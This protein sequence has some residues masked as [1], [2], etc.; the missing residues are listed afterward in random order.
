MKLLIV[1]SPSK[2]KTINQYLGK[3]FNVISSYGHVRGLP[4]ADGSVKPDENFKMVYEVH[5]RSEKAVSEIIKQVKKC[6]ELLLASDPDREGEGISWHILEILKEKKILD[7][8]KVKRVVFNEITKKAVTDAVEH[9]RDINYDL[10]HAQQARQAL[11]YLYGF[12][13]SPVL[14]RKLPGSRSAGRVQSV[15]LRMI[16]DREIEIERFISTEFWSITSTMLTPKKVEFSAS[17][18]MFEGGKL[19]RFSIANQQQALAIK[20][21]LLKHSYH[22][23]NKESKQVK[24][25]PQP[26]FT[27]ST[28]L[29]EAARKLGFS[30]KKTSKIAQDLYEG[31]EIN[32]K[33]QGLITYMRTDS[34]AISS[35]AQIAARNFITSEF[36]NK[37]LP[38]KPRFYKNKS[39][40]AQEAHE[41]IRPTN[42]EITPAITLKSLSND[43][44]RL[45]ELIW[46]RLV[47]SQ[48]ES[49]VFDQ[50]TIDINS[51]DNA[52]TFRAVGTTIAFD[53]YFKLY[54]EDV[55]DSEDEDKQLLPA[56][57]VGDNVDL[58][59]LIEKQHFTQ[60][61]PRYTE[62]S[63][64]KKMEEL[65]IGRPSTY[66]GIISL[67][68]ERGYVRADKKR[69]FPEIKG[70]LV[71]SFLCAFF[72]QYVDYNFTAKLED[73]LDDIS[74]GDKPMTDVLR[75]FW[76]PFKSK[77]EEALQLKI[78]DVIDMVQND[79]GNVIY[80][81]L[82][83]DHTCPKCKIGK[84][85]IRFGKFGPFLGCSNYPNCDYTKPIADEASSSESTEA[86]ENIQKQDEVMFPKILGED[87]DGSVISLRKGP[88]GVYVQKEKGKDIKR[89]GIPKGYDLNKV[90]LSYALAM[91]S[92]PRVVGEHPDG[93]TI[94]AGIG[95][96]G[97]YLEHNKK[98]KSLKNQDP[99][100]VDL[101][102]AV[103][104][105]AEPVVARA[106]ASKP[107]AK[108]KK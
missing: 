5:E 91:L 33:T 108:K 31:M 18:I 58:K 60:P 85:S 13:L 55:D 62:A 54:M 57:E 98:F 80:K 74:I 101:A 104:I 12:T 27:T 88:Y 20:E 90:T 10:V 15:A 21:S 65:G 45:Y 68:Q 32:G 94:K 105:L 24:R 39:K 41:A 17:L 43:H 75:E 47:A 42:V 44:Q 46:K 66:P 71:S 107:A 36:G 8:I 81:D 97:P 89:T 70:R 38:E 14:W 37:Y 102:T 103:A 34:V 83:P 78:S 95:R 63:L 40:N 77:T 16:C 49:A 48:M 30:A 3:D 87:P 59:E 25:N 26:P 73:E 23:A 35:D 106:R 9:P 29:Q 19:E 56:M 6:D 11:D 72:P 99:V 1:E 53:G 76:T 7:K 28:M 22:V 100:N 82:D 64:V 51:Q 96:F 79:L 86:S 50:V 69:F 93:G 52:N 2:A 67:L 4:S 84:I 92:L 61:P